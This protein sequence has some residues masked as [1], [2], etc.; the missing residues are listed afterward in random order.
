MVL[1]KALILGFSSY[2]CFYPLRQKVILIFISH[3][4]LLEANWKE[5]T[6]YTRS[7]PWP[8][9]FLCRLKGAFDGCSTGV[10]S[11]VNGVSTQRFIETSPSL[12]SVGVFILRLPLTLHFTT[13]IPTVG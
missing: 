5:Q 9:R 12:H 6:A 1:K 2:I 10:R 13:L 7:S 8:V 11:V 4:Q 3:A